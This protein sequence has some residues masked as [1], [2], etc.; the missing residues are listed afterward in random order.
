M[1]TKSDKRNK[2][3]EEV[4]PRANHI[5][6][7]VPFRYCPRVIFLGGCRSIGRAISDLSTIV[8]NQHSILSGTV[9]SFFFKKICGVGT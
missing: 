5:F 8:E 6:G 1:G 2:Q 9:S 4:S 7:L 3:K